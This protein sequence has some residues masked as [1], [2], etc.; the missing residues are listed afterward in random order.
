MDGDGTL[1]FAPEIELATVSILWHEPD[2]LPEFLRTIDLALHFQQPHLRIIIEAISLSYAELAVSDF[3]TV[4]QTVRELGGFAECGGLEGLNQVYSAHEPVQAIDPEYAAILKQQID[5]IFADYLDLLG[6]YA[7]TRQLDPPR[8]VYR[9]SSGRGTAY[10]NKVKRA[11]RDPDFRGEAIV[12][13]R[14]YALSLDVSPD[15]DSI[16]LSLEPK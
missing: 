12:R 9:F 2:R 13:G 15:G 4:V 11:R 5:V 3:A 7:I 10:R 6:R 1:L 14:H 8:P 16:N